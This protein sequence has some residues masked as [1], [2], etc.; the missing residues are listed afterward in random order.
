MKGQGEDNRRSYLGRGFELRQLLSRSLIT[1]MIYFVKQCFWLLPK[2]L[3]KMSSEGE[4]C[5]EWE[6]LLAR[7]ETGS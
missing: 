1:E 2:E 4:G 7:E 5:N 6:K 3:L